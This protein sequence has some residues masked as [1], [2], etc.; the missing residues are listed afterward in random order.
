ML[1]PTRGRRRSQGRG[2]Q[3]GAEATQ[4]THCTCACWRTAHVHVG[5]CCRAH[6]HVGVFCRVHLAFGALLTGTV[7]CRGATRAQQRRWYAKQSATAHLS[8]VRR[9][10]PLDVDRIVL[11]ACGVGRTPSAA[12]DAWCGP[13]A[14]TE[15]HPTGTLVTLVTGS[16]HCQATPCCAYRPAHTREGERERVCAVPSCPPHALLAPP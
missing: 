3:P 10:R 1:A 12:S 11:H 7:G 9:P 14:T 4:C 8:K 16:C 5:V 15:C 6:L 13:L 2:P